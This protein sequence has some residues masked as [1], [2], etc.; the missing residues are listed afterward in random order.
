MVVEKLP[1]GDLK[2]QS[3][4]MPKDIIL[5]PASLE[6]PIPEEPRLID[7]AL[8]TNRNEEAGQLERNDLRLHNK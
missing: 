5:N 8:G 4:G 1:T 6:P 7:V 3:A 2:F